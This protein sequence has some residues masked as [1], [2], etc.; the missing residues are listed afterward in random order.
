LDI[1]RRG[2]CSTIEDPSLKNTGA[3]ETHLILLWSKDKWY[4]FDW[5][6]MERFLKGIMYKLEG[7]RTD[8]IK[9]TKIATLKKTI[10]LGWAKKGGGRTRLTKDRRGGSIKKERISK[11][12]S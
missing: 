8:V 2:G 1:V 10:R 11:E 3:R 4:S 5:T 7:Y 9:S 6:W 12:K